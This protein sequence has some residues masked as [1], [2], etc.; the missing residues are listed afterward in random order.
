MGQVGKTSVK[1]AKRAMSAEDRA[2]RLAIEDGL[3]GE[4]LSPVPPDSLNDRQKEVYKWLYDEL[5]PV[6]ILGELD[7]FTMCNACIIIE[8]LEKIDIALEEQDAFVSDKNL[9]AL[10][11]DYFAQYLKICGE[12]CLSPASRAKIGTLVVAKRQ[13]DDLMSVLGV[14]E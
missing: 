9:H 4:G 13:K 14:E 1:T 3:A 6:K 2:K 8:R 10:R 11:K 5:A 7:R 12:L